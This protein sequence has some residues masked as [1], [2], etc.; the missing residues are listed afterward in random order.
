MSWGVFL[1]KALK[2]SPPFVRVF[3]ARS[4]GGIEAN[5]AVEI[6]LI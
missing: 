4:E 6:R 5:E 2:C 1:W 3:V